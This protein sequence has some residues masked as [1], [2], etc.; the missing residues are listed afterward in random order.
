MTESEYP[1]ITYLL[2]LIWHAQKSQ[3]KTLI[4]PQSTSLLKIIHE[5]MKHHLTPVR[6]AI[7]K[8]STDGER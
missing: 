6:M 4:L 2:C 8:K 3:C 7:I 1:T 5:T